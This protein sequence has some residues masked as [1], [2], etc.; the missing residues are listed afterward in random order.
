MLTEQPTAENEIPRGSTA[1]TAKMVSIPLGLAGRSALGF[2]RQ[3]VGQSGSLVFAEIQE[4][5]AE[6]VQ[7]TWRIKRR[8]YEIWPSAFSI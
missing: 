2:G 4:K 5:T 3:L 7:S 6:Q 8:G 1:R